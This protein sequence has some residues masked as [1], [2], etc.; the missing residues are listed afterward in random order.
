MRKRCCSIERSFWTDSGSGAR[1]SAGVLRACGG[2][3]ERGR[4][5]GGHVKRLRGLAVFGLVHH[6]LGIWFAGGARRKVHVVR[7]AGHERTRRCHTHNQAIS[8]RALA[9]AAAVV[10]EVRVIVAMAM[11]G[12][13][14]SANTLGSCRLPELRDGVVPAHSQL[15]GGAARVWRRGECSHELGVSGWVRGGA[16]GC[17]ATLTSQLVDVHWPL[18]QPSASSAILGVPA[19]RGH[20]WQRGSQPA[21]TAS[22]CARPPPAADPPGSQPLAPQGVSAWPACS[23]PAVLGPSPGLR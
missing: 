10:G 15:S 17:D 19:A 4:A 2:G 22:K 1:S 13:L 21:T 6:L 14:G 3:Q 8:G 12:I 16:G 11:A 9:T 7:R 18:L 20:D 5:E 23:K